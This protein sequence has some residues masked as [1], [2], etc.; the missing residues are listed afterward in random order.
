MKI[1]N[2]NIL[3]FEK[4]YRTNFV[5]SLSGFKSANLI[6]TISKEGKTNL[7][8][9]SS[10]IH[11][12]ANPPLIGML[13]RPASVPRHTYENIKDIG[14]FTINHINKEIFKQAYQTSARYEKDVS[15]FDEC[16]LT[17]E[18]TNT[19]KAPYVKESN[20]KI[21]CR[22]VEEHLIKTNDTI[23][24]VGEILEVN[25]PDDVLTDDGYIDIEIAG[26]LAISG[27]DSYH[28]TKRISRLSYAKPGI[29]AREK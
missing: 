2:E 25:I 28:E 5:N 9:F 3:Q 17:P 14:Y 23:F 26:T 19:I 18:F 16:G 7:A 21:G 13:V 12:G 29:E 20:I 6:G 24:V 11:V 27:L 4:L 8:I 15:E 22:F 10:V 1:T